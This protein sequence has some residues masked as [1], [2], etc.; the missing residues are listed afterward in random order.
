MKHI[1]CFLTILFASSVV[2]QNQL[3]NEKW[4]VDDSLG[5]ALIHTSI[6]N[7]LTSTTSLQQ[8]KNRYTLSKDNT[9][10]QPHGSIT[11]KNGDGRTFKTFITSIPL[12][13]IDAP[14]GIVNEPKRL[15]KIKYTDADTTFT[16]YAGIELR[17]SSSLIFAK[18]TYDLNF[19]KD[20]TGKENSDVQLA[21]M[22][23]D[24]DW[25][26]DG[27]FNE[28]LRMRSYL[29]L[30]LWN[31]IYQPYYLDREP[32]A[33]GGAQGTYADVFVNGKYQ[34]IFL[35]QE[36][37]DRKLTRI[38][39]IKDDTVRG[40]LFQGAS[41]N[42]AVT[43]DSLPK[44]KNYLP[45]WGGYN[46]KYPVPTNIYWDNLYPFTDFVIN[47]S[48]DA[49]AKAIPHKFHLD[50]AV[51]Y[52]LFINAVRAPDNLG[53]NLFLVRYTKNEPYFYAPW[54]LDGTFGTIFSGKRI[55]TTDDFLQNGL[56]RRLI[57]TNADG[58]VSSFQQ[59]WS[60]L[61]T[62]VFATEN[63]LRRQADVYNKLLENRMFERESLVWKEFKYDPEGL[64]YMQQWTQERL[65]FLDTY[66]AA[67]PKGTKK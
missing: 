56:L 7:V 40:E 63:I 33:K 5:L 42:G 45:L 15:A 16:S 65:L 22:R 28:P 36:Q 55:P 60:T 1:L 17:G 67:I 43:F 58:F 23:K 52:F 4:A 57:A 61:R 62:G 59:R 6:K 64:E 39:K 11:F 25:V 30:N 13:Q 21:G 10:P 37:V 26:L 32:K 50:N 38:K 2:G 53:K 54:D 18:K 24:D 8:G 49:F 41:Y 48:D 46:V 44:K 47:S 34:G 29:S 12:I 3:P 66:I 20:S 27:L 19:Y 14:Q 51:N 31:E 35:L 9:T